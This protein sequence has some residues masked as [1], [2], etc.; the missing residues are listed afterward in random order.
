VAEILGRIELLDAEH[1]VLTGGEP[2]LFAEMI[3][4]CEGIKKS[5]RHITIETAGTLHLPLSC[6]LMSIS[7]K[8]S[9]SAPDAEDYPRWH[10]RHEQTRQQIDIVQ[11]LIDTYPYQLK[12]VV[13]KPDDCDEIVTY[14]NQLR[15]LQRDC[16]YLMPQGTK[17]DQLNE[18]TRWLTSLADQHG[19]QICHRR[20]IEWFGFI[21]GT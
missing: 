5:G 20:H 21:R 3:P 16:V 11:R 14:L 6:D 4:L 9:N 7:P 13:D 15:G 2:M 1:I 12:F 17:A 19:L 18:K 8:M 10:R